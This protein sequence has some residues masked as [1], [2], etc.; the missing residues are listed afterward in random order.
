MINKNLP[1]PEE[2]YRF[3]NLCGKNKRLNKRL[4]HFPNENCIKEKIRMG[5]SF[6]EEYIE[7]FSFWYY[8]CAWC[9][10]I[11]TKRKNKWKGG[12]DE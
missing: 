9:K 8:E 2:Q 10:A 7:T 5:L 11:E 6:K 4:I 1:E 12:R 3:C